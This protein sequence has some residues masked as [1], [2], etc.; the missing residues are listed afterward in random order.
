MSDNRK[1]WGDLTRAAPDVTVT[2]GE[3]RVAFEYWEDSLLGGFYDPE[4]PGDVPVY[5]LVVYERGDDGWNVAYERPTKLDLTM[6]HWTLLYWAGKVMKALELLP[7]A[8]AA[9]ACPYLA[10]EEEPAVA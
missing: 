8:E 9:A 2:V 6:P 3:S 7:P 1:H 4:R 10:N 5:H